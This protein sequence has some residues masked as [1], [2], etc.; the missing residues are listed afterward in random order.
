MQK[1]LR[2][3]LWIF[4]ISFFVAGAVFYRVIHSYAHRIREN[5][6]AALALAV[7]LPGSAPISNK[8]WSTADFVKTI[9]QKPLVDVCDWFEGKGLGTFQQM[10]AKPQFLTSVVKY[11]PKMAVGLLSYRFPLHQALALRL[12]EPPSLAND[13]RLAL[14]TRKARKELDEYLPF[15]RQVELQNYYAMTLVKVVIKDPHLL[16]NSKVNVLCQRIANTR[17]LLTQKDMNNEIYGFMKTARVKPEDVGFNPKYVP[18]VR[19]VEKSEG[20]WEYSVPN[21]MLR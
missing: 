7:S 13:I 11:K 8:A 2:R 15:A 1:K 16:G 6:K 21:E 10:L 18:S 19:V 4:L 20:L 9:S 14:E 3:K 17:N 5:Q 12:D